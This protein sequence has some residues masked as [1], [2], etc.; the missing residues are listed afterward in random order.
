MLKFLPHGLLGLMVA[1]L[2][3]AYV[4]TM[5]TQLNWG[6]SYLVHD[7]Y[8]R[9][10][11]PGRDERHYVLAGRLTTGLLMLAAALVTLVLETARA[12][13]DLLLSIGAGTGLLYLLRWFWWRI[14]AWSEIAAMVSSFLLALGFFVAGR[15]GA[16]VPSHV[17]LIATVLAT[18]VIWIAATLLTPPVDQSTL[19]RFYRLTRPAGPG[20]AAVRARS[21]L[22]ASP[23][24]LPQMLLGWVL[25]C[26]FVYSA[27]FGGGSLVYGKTGPALLWA[28][29][30]LVS[31]FGLLRL[32]PRLWAGS[33]EAG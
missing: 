7:F 4:S 12:S 13:F 16:V 14:N 22:P 3:A 19:E 11:R 28:T 32:L 2:L 25:G 24:S 5:S 9:F 8:R 21:G 17:A 33:G 27:L 23:D 20:W 15:L 29:M 26:L 18:T 10:L 6:T 1:G 30:F 31:G